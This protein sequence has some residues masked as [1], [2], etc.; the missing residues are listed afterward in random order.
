MNFLSIEIPTTDRYIEP[1]T[2]LQVDLF[3][4][5]RRWRAEVADARNVPAYRIMPDYKIKELAMSDNV[6]AA[7][8]RFIAGEK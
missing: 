6:I 5:I 2:D 8:W 1:L 4:Q 3:R 7:A